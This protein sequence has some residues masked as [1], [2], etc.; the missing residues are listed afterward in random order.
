MTIINIL[1]VLFFYLGPLEPQEIF[2]LCTCTGP[3]DSL[4]RNT[5]AVRHIR[6]TQDAL[7]SGVARTV[8]EYLHAGLQSIH[9]QLS[10][11][12]LPPHSG[13]TQ[14]QKVLP[15]QDVGFGWLPRFCKTG[16][17]VLTLSVMSM[18]YYYRLAVKPAADPS[19]NNSIFN[20]QECIYCGIASFIVLANLVFLCQSTSVKSLSIRFSRQLKTPDISSMPI[21]DW[22]LPRL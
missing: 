16:M 13:G 11:H 5:V 14:D 17:L 19:D 18:H 12:V 9:T 4:S 7:V 10:Q 3:L 6:P 22:D 21:P 8:A 1:H 2:D 20:M 15:I